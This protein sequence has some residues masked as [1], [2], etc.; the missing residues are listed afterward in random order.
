MI[1]VADDCVYVEKRGTRGSASAVDLVLPSYVVLSL[2]IE[3]LSAGEMVEG[4][5]LSDLEKAFGG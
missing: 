5:F 1:G 3:T 4:L 2:G